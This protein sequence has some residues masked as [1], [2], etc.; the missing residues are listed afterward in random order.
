MIPGAG[1]EVLYAAKNE[2]GTWDYSSQAKLVVLVWSD[3]E[4]G[5]LTGW[6]V[7]PSETGDA[8]STLYAAGGVAPIGADGRT[9]YFVKYVP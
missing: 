3:N 9:Q 2:D 8:G 4:A 6:V 7:S 5:N 1:W